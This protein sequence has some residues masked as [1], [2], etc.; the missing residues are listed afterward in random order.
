MPENAA[1]WSVQTNTTVPTTATLKR[2]DALTDR[3]DDASALVPGYA[4]ATQR[5]VATSLDNQGLLGF[6]QYCRLHK[7]PFP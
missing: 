5:H 1:P 3:I 7:L 6:A 2:F 4:Y